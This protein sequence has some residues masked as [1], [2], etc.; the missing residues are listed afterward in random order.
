MNQSEPPQKAVLDGY[1]EDWHWHASKTHLVSAY[2]KCAMFANAPS[3]RHWET[4]GEITEQYTSKNILKAMDFAILG[5][6]KGKG[7]G[8]LQEPYLAAVTVYA[9]NLAVGKPVF[10][11]PR[12]PS[13]PLERAAI[14]GKGLEILAKKLR[15]AGVL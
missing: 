11:N 12:L 6:D 8:G 7:Q 5:D 1:L 9:R 13:D 10:N 3:P 14:T 4:A 15:I 2:G